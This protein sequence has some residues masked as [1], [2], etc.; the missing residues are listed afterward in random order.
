MT[1]D[2]TGMKPILIYDT[3]TL[4]NVTPRYSTPENKN[5]AAFST[6]CDLLREVNTD[7]GHIC[8]VK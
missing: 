1:C 7:T 3:A 4:T 8:S 6:T 2:N 5:I